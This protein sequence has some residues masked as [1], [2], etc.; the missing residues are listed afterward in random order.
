MREVRRRTDGLADASRA[1][2][3]TSV[4]RAER[5][6][7]QWSK[8]KNKLYARHAPEAECFSQDKARQHYEFGVKVRLAVTHRHGLMLGRRGCRRTRD[9]V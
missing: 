7:Q 4:Q 3:D 2:L 6:L 1:R 8:D 9:R 5:I